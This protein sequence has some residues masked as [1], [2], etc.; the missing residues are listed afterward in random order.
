LKFLYYLLIASRENSQD[1]TFR[2]HDYHLCKIADQK[3]LLHIEDLYLETG[4]I[5]A[6]SGKIGTG[7]T[8]FLSDIAGYL[9]SN[10]FS[11]SGTM[12]YPTIEGK[13]IPMI[14]CNATPFSPPDTTLFQCLTYRLPVNYINEAAKTLSTHI[15]DIFEKT[16]QTITEEILSDKGFKL[17]T[18]Q[19]KIAI[20]VAAI[21]YKEYLESPVMLAL[22]ETLANLDKGTSSKICYMIKKVFNDS[23]IVSVDHNWESSNDFYQNNIDLSEFCPV[24]GEVDNSADIVL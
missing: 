4:L 21:L 13:T 2:V 1:L 17:S 20:L 16:G 23:I 11:S 19:G 3:D 9:N 5:Y 14:F 15:I 10:A 24:V 12:Y 18:G 8:T 6:I 7:K 22:D